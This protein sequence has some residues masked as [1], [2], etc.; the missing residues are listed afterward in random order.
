MIPDL[1]QTTELE[2]AESATESAKALPTETRISPV[3]LRTFEEVLELHK[4]WLDSQG[5]AGEQADLSGA[6]LEDADLTDAKLRRANLNK[7]SLKRAD[8]LLVDL[9]E[10]SL[11]RANLENAILLGA[12][13]AEANL[14][15]AYLKGVVGL[16]DSQ[17][18]GTN[19]FG[20][21][22][23]EPRSVFER[24]KQVHEVAYRTGWFL[25]A[26]L[27]VNGL[28]WLRIVT[29]TDA[30]L[31]RNAPALSLPALRH[32]LPL[33]PFYLFGPVLV[34]TVYVNFHL[35]LQ[36]LW[37]GQAGLPAILPDGRPLDSCF[38]W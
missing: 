10:A 16:D 35:H 20:A 18:A 12:Q 33:I 30:Q 29:T 25:L 4:E 3:A 6:Q 28:A 19:L 13:F 11:L 37:E 15:G 22:L 32:V 9:R 26:M 23:P 34:L 14:Q 7:A 21:V 5:K 24:L 27:L 38:L 17:L 31:L 2:M 8:L 1:I 36:R